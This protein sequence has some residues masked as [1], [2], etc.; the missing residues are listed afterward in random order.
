M[1][2]YAYIDTYVYMYIY[3]YMYIYFVYI[4]IY[5]CSSIDKYRPCD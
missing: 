1:P 3:I 2:I 5:I 4:Y